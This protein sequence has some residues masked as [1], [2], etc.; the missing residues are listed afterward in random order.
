MTATRWLEM[1]ERLFPKLQKRDGNSESEL[2][3]AEKRLGFTLPAELRAM[4]RLAGRRRDL[5]AA[6]DRLVSPNNLITVNKALVFYEEAERASAWA[7]PRKDVEQDDPPVVTAHNQ[8]PFAWAPDHD[9]LSEFFF[10][11]LLWQHVNVDPHV[12]LDGSPEYIARVRAKYEEVPLP[13]CHWD[14]LGCW[15]SEG[16]VVMVRGASETACKV[17][18]GATSDEEL[19]RVTAA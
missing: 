12:V 18:V 11:E 19:E 15:R 10:T 17:Y 2:K 5:H 6:H 14:I 3:T 1:T 16:A 9:A 4:Y 13:G 8:P 7:I